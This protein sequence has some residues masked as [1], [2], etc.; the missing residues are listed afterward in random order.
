MTVPP[1]AR[2]DRPEL[3]ATRVMLRPVA[4]PFALGFLGLAK[5]VPAIVLAAIGTRLCLTATAAPPVTGRP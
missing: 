3:A 4:S 5:L 1:A 2:D